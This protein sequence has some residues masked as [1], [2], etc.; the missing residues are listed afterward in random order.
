MNQNVYVMK[1]KPDIRWFWTFIIVFL[2]LILLA[3][4]VK[5]VNAGEAGVLSLFGRVYKNPV[6]SG[7]H[8]INPFVTLIRYPTRTL[9][10]TM[11]ATTNEGAIQG[12]DSISVLTKDGLEIRLDVTVW[13]RL[14]EAK[15]PDIYSKIGLTY[16][17]KIIRPAV[18]TS[19]REASVKRNSSAI[20]KEERAELIKD[21]QI[22]IANALEPRGIIL[23]NVLLRDV[24]LPQRVKDAIEEKLQADQEA[25]KMEYVLVKS[26]LERKRV[27][28][29]AKAQAQRIQIINKALAENPKYLQWLA[30]DKLNDNV[31]VIIN[32]GK[33]ILNLDALRDS[34]N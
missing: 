9:A 25:Q 26:E 16:E 30:I 1:T 15:L 4:S 19:I 33:S 18:R 28:I 32:D 2:L 20:Y 13:Y 3:K 22:Y 27:E 23:E 5:V 11:S 21:I 12:D 8:L 10:Y 29:E 24:Q 31:K 17:D 14:D 6:R 7:L 34:S